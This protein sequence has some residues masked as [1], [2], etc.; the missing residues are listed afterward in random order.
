MRKEK[1]E[2]HKF[3]KHWWFVVLLWAQDLCYYILQYAQQSS[4]KHFLLIW[5]LETAETPQSFYKQRARG[6]PPA[7]EN[8]VQMVSALQNSK[9]TK[10]L[11]IV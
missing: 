6:R 11:V 8:S 10:I 2:A 1:S 5:F 9:A 4:T 3:Q 7:L